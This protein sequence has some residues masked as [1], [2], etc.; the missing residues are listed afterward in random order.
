MTKRRKKF[1]AKYAAKLSGF[2]RALG[3]ATGPLPPPGRLRDAYVLGWNRG[4]RLLRH[5]GRA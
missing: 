4:R 1:E 5:E 2:G 3:Q